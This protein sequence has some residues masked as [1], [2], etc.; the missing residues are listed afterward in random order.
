MYVRIFSMTNFTPQMIILKYH[1]IEKI[2]MTKNTP[3]P[4]MSF[5]IYV[6]FDLKLL[7]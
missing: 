2:H 1:T 7:Y 6:I 5:E 4:L 3:I